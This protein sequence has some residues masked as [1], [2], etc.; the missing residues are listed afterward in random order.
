M[1]DAITLK[2][3]AAYEGAKAIT[4]AGDD[5]EGLAASSVAAEKDLR[6]LQKQ[7]K[8]VSGFEKLSQELQDN[9]TALESS[10]K[11]MQ[12][13]GKATEAAAKPSAE[14]RKEYKASQTEVKKLET[15][16]ARQNKSPS[17]QE[18]ALTGAGIDT[19]RLGSEQG[20]LKGKI[21]LATVAADKQRKSLAKQT[22]TQA[23]LAEVQERTNKALQRAANLS[24]AANSANALAANLLGPLNRVIEATKTQ[25]A[26]E[27][28]LEARII[29]TGGAAGLSADELKS[30]ASE[31]QGLTL[32]GD[33]ATIQMQSLLLTFTQIQGPVFREAT[34]IILD[35]STALGTDLKGASIQVGKALNDPI[36]GVSALA[37]VGVSFTQSQKDLIASLVKTGDVA[38]AQRVILAELRVEY[39]GAAAAAVDTFGGALGQLDGVVADLFEAGSGLPAAKVAIQE[40]TKALADP[41]LLAAVDSMAAGLV[42]L[43]A[44]AATA[45][46][47][48]AEFAAE[49][50]GLIKWLGGAAIGVGALAAVMGP[51]FTIISAGTATVALFNGSLATMVT[52]GGAAAASVTGVGTAA[53]ASTASIGLLGKALRLTPWGIA[54]AGA[55]GAVVAYNELTAASERLARAQNSAANERQLELASYRQMQDEAFKYSTELIKGAAA[56]ESLSAAEQK[57][58]IERLTKA[59]QYYAAVREEARLTGNTA[60]LTSAAA[61]VALYEAGLKSARAAM[62]A[63]AEPLPMSVIE[64]DIAQ[65]AGG[66]RQLA[67]EGKTAKVVIQEMVSGLDFD[68]LT[69]GVQV[70]VAA[71]QQLVTEGTLAADVVGAELGAALAKLSGEDL[72]AFQE[73]SVAAFGATAETAEELALVL[74]ATLGVALKQLGI[75]ADNSGSTAA[76]AFALLAGNAN[77]TAEQLQQGLVATLAKLDNDTDLAQVR[78]AV[79]ALAAD[80]RVT[81]QALE[82]AL[83]AVDQKARELAATL[84]GELSD[85][86]ARMGIKS[87]AELAAIA[88][89]AKQDYALIRE[90][91][92]ATSEELA[93]AAGRYLAAEQAAHDGVLPLVL[94]VTQAKDDLAKAAD[95]AGAAGE[96]AGKRI[97][98]GMREA[99]GAAQDAAASIAEA[100]AASK[101][102]ADAARGGFSGGGTLGYREQV[103]ATGDAQ[104][105]ADYDRQIAKVSDIGRSLDRQL[106]I[107]A[108]IAEQ[109]L[110]DAERRAATGTTAGSAAAGAA[111]AV[112]EKTVRWVFGGKSVNASGDTDAF[113]AELERAGVVSSS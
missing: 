43:V 84:T 28:Q 30:M 104:A 44:E 88:A 51:L 107:Y 102:A 35:M 29:S 77:A 87:R 22:K 53:A 59:R 56:V 40:L 108:G 25:E 50:A 49:N 67:T 80:G 66:L 41:A 112:P 34:E 45:A 65:V 91:G 5:I 13:L 2:I 58:Y 105:L 3:R 7:S 6:G 85:A 61:E 100:E 16:I 11:R 96:A 103:A 95:R 109:V 17:R 89:Q 8:D 12:A 113:F 23:K 55:V 106:D 64:Q 63:L 82:A 36:K 20:K 93:K 78:A 57:S 19:K 31:L 9:E 14:L 97:A 76:S 70:G 18:K 26:A 72:L 94:E 47:G 46:K 52:R 32:Y 92:L 38:G 33:E 4:Q 27:A 48:F 111:A 83:D 75:A 10:R 90:S 68:P 98:A 69:A 1:A 42:A 81:G 71:L 15:A 74:D 99:S 79:Q 101:A 73:Q 62:V 54:I 110:R 60:E 37:D 39:G 86:F 21:A 24:L